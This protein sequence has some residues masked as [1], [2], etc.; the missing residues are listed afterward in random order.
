MNTSDEIEIS[1]SEWET[2]RV[3]WTLQK[4]TSHQ[5]IEILEEKLGWKASTT[6]TY[7]GRLV[8]KGL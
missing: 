4:A 3:I 5:I 6:K 2:M 1:Q 7:L 8:K